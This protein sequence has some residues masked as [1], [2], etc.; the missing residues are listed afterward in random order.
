MFFF[1]GISF[2]FVTRVC[3]WFSCGWGFTVHFLGMDFFKEMRFFQGLWDDVFLFCSRDVFF[4]GLRT[5][6]FKEEF[7]VWY[8]VYCFLGLFYGDDQL[9][10]FNTI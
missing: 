9:D 6:F 4:K 7:R 5:L 3:C 10:V 8:C 1:L 2:N